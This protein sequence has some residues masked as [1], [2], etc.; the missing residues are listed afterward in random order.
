M[1]LALCR[2]VTTAP[3]AYTNLL[4]VRVT[5]DCGDCAKTFPSPAPHIDILDHAYV[6]L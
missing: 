5:R 4:L 2:R 6:K 1:M 3:V